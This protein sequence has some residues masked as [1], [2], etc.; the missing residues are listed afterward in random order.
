MLHM[1]EKYGNLRIWALGSRGLPECTCLSGCAGARAG[2]QAGARCSRDASLVPCSC[3]SWRTSTPSAWRC[4]MRHRRS[5]RTSG[6]RRCPT[7]RPAATTRWACF[8][9]YVLLLLLLLLL[10]DP[11]SHPRA[12]WGWSVG[13]AS[14]FA[15][16]IGFEPRA[17]EPSQRPLRYTRQTGFFVFRPPH[18]R[19]PSACS[20]ERDFSRN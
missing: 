17:P 19:L 10:G 2:A 13:A 7:P 8:P 9:W 11:C 12:G 5:S 16:W 1:K 14:R 3:A 15:A 18:A 4:S 20:D 6:T